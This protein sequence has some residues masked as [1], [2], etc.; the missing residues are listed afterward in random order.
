MSNTNKA[1]I[2]IVVVIMLAIYVVVP[3]SPGIPFGE[4]PKKFVTRLG[5]DLV[6][7]VQALL[8]ADLPAGTNIDSEAMRTA[9]TIV[10]NRVN[11]LG[12]NEAVVQQAGD[13]RIVVE[14]PGETDPEEAL[15]VLRQTGLLEFVDFSALTDQEIQTLL[16]SQTKIKTD[17]GLS[18]EDA[19]IQPTPSSTETITSSQTITNPLAS[20]SDTIFHTIMTGAD[21][22]TAAVTTNQA[23]QYEI[24][25]ELTENG[26][27][28]FAEHT[29][30]HI[31]DV[32]AIVLDKEIISAP[33]INDAIPDGRGVIQGSFD[34]ESA[35]ALAVQLRYGSLPIPLVVVETRTVGP[36]L[37]QDS[38]QKSMLAGLVGFIIVVL[39]MII[40]YR[41]SGLMAVLSILIYALIVFAIFR[42]VPVTLTLAGI[43]GFLLS[44]GSALDAN[45]LIFERIKEELRAGKNLKLSLDLAFKRARPAI[46]D[47]NIATLITCAILFWFGSTFGATIVK[48]FS[49]TLAIGVG[50][51]LFT[52]M[53]VTRTMM[54]LTLN[55]FKSTDYAKWFGI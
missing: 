50:V 30:A 20:L 2:L 42:G 34:Q 31:G 43:A 1:L 44:T 12:V 3:N 21:L 22:K 23:N 53:V 45:I 7:G 36:T 35:N 52:A 11:G 41:L 24:S 48:G 25:F 47:S 18:E 6:G 8:E 17:F 28:I 55:N 15:A 49:I 39:F 54:T 46:I 4:N 10:E 38:L 27:G 29:A 40:Y 14:L 9:T 13:R 26:A 5:L 33:G 37:G 51:S 32:L 16:N 19:S